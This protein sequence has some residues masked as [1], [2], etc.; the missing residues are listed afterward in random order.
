MVATE[1][2]QPA[3]NKRLT[4]N[5]LLD[6]LQ[7]RSFS[8]SANSH[9]GKYDPSGCKSAGFGTVLKRDPMEVYLS[10]TA[11]I[12]IPIANTQQENEAGNLKPGS[13]HACTQAVTSQHFV[14]LLIQRAHFE[15]E[16]AQKLPHVGIAPVQNRTDADN[17]RPA[18]VRL[19]KVLQ[20]RCGRT[21][22]GTRSHRN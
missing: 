8:P 13:K 10:T 21:T 1:D 4:R 9:A 20:A 14:P 11:K 6:F 5:Q 18:S 16:S 15:I 7:S 3:C 19:L 17:F 12:N 2:K 22:T